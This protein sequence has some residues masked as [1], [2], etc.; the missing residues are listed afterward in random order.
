[1]TWNSKGAHDGAQDRIKFFSRAS[2]QCSSQMFLPAAPLS[3]YPAYA[4][5]AFA[6]PEKKKKDKKKGFCC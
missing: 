2:S 4:Y 5:P 1:M 6:A 3:S